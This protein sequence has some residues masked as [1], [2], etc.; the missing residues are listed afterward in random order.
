L[1]NIYF[2]KNGSLINS[3]NTYIST[4]NLY[5]GASVQCTLLTSVARQASI[6]YIGWKV[7]V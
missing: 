3:I 7:I 5:I 1:N 6:D 4:Q 2:F